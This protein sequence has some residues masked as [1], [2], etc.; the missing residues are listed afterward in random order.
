MTAIK[1]ISTCRRGE[2]ESL[3][4]KAG[5]RME[6]KQHFSDFEHGVF[7]G[8]SFTEVAHRLV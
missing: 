2:D 8:A 1:C 5:V 3:R 7:L 6:E 4:F